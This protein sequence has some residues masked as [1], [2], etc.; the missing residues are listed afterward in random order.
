[1]TISSCASIFATSNLTRTL[2][3]TLER[4]QCLSTVSL[5]DTNVHVVLLLNLCLFLSFGGVV[6]GVGGAKFVFTRVRKRIW[7]RRVA[8]A[9]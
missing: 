2:W 9:Q 3:K 5:L 7:H 4:R 1:M 6:F 8:I